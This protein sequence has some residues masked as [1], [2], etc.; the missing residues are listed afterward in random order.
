MA[1]T[2]AEFGK[3]KRVLMHRPGA[4]FDLVNEQNLAYYNF[5]AVP[6]MALY[7]AHFD[8]LTAA[9]TARGAQ[10]LLLTDVLKDHR[11]A[12]DY[13]AA[14]P[15]V[16]YTRDLAVVTAA[17]VILMGMALES[18]KGDTWVIGAALERLGIPIL[19][20]IAGP[21]LLEGGGVAFIDE[22]TCVAGI[23]DRANDSGIRQLCGLIFSAGAAEEVVLLPMP[24]GTIHIDG[25]FMAVGPKV[26]LIHRPTISE[27]PARVLRKGRLVKEIPFPDLLAERGF[28]LIELTDEEKADAALNIVVTEP[29]RGVGYETGQ[30]LFRELDKFGGDY[31]A[32]PFP[33]LFK[34]CAGPHCMTCPIERV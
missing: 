30:R 7:L 22:T 2:A 3:L 13:I 28:T 18:R 4:E 34:G 20:E 21:G 32:V 17:G 23:C 15:N 1:R 11:E 33:E 27:Y 6:D 19:G 5:R 31:T 8:Q 14:H 26:A 12:L 29:F 25:E 16:T 9:I 10:V 24:K